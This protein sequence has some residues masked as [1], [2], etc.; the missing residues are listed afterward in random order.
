MMRKFFIVLFMLAALGGTGFF[1][2]WVQLAVPPGSYGVLRS[3]THGI[4]MSPIREGEFRWVWFK[5]IPSNVTIEVYRLPRVER[6]ITHRGVLPS[7]DVYTAFASVD[8]DFSYEFE[9]VL[10]FSIDA[11]SLI[12]LIGEWDIQNQEELEARA[13][14]LGQDIEGFVLRRLEN[15]EGDEGELLRIMETGSSARLEGEVRSNF[16]VIRDFSCRI[17]AI[18]FPDFRL[19]SQLRGLYTD[20]LNK[21]R[22][23]ILAATDGRA[24]RRIDSRFRLD[25][26]AA[27]GDLLTRYPVLLEYLKLEAAE[28]GFK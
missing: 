9:A 5:L 12:P 28:T 27:Y 1:L 11:E 22:D 13:V 2:G 19:Y 10:S 15:L 17:P 8:A 18:R 21:Q 3:K 7:A 24:E 23:Y 16:P 20:Y 25:E 26:L 4:D 6:R 14:S